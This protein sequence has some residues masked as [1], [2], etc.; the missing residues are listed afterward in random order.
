MDENN[1][2]SKKGGTGGYSYSINIPPGGLT[3]I[4][5]QQKSIANA[6]A[7]LRELDTMIPEKYKLAVKTKTLAVLE[8]YLRH[9]E[10]GRWCLLH[11]ALTVNLKICK[12]EL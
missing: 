1:G 6:E 2:D 3:A 9:G 11:L 7:A 4:M 5:E 12:D 10:A 8:D